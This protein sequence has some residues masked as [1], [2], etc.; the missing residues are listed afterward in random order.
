MLVENGLNI[1]SP[2]EADEI[3]NKTNNI[4]ILDVRTEMEHNYEGMIED[5]ISINFLKPR[6]A[7]REISKLDKNIPY[8]LYCSIG[9]LSI[10]AAEY[11]KEHGFNNIYV[12]EGGLKAWNKYFGDNNKVSKFDREESSERR[13]K[14]II[15]LNR[16]EGQIKGM[17]KMLAKGEYCGDILNQS[18]AVKSA[19]GSVNQE[20]MEVFLNTCMISTKEKED[21]FRYMRKLIK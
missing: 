10:K 19:M 11:M 9:K 3:I 15:R 14:L 13:K 4:V 16:I 2:S 17:K 12:L 21:F 5:S 6:V 20:I 7:K 1:L 8:L 18:L